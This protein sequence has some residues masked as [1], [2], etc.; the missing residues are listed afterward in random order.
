LLVASIGLLRR[1]LACFPLHENDTE[2][3]I[4]KFQM[5][6]CYQLLLL[7][8][9]FLRLLSSKLCCICEQ[10]ERYTETL[11][12]CDVTDGNPDKTPAVRSKSVFSTVSGES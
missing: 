3:F 2:G 7:S 11:K 6:L 8:S 12:G 5:S 4:K 1:R 9:S 10:P